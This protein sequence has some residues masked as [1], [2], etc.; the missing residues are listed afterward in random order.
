MAQSQE[1]EH[2]IEMANS[3][4][5]TQFYRELMLQSHHQFMNIG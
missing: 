3:V 4:N 2:A 1:N 5:K